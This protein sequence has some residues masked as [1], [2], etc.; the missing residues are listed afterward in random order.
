MILKIIKES[1]IIIKD[2]NP[3]TKN[4]ILIQKQANR[5]MEQNRKCRNRRYVHTGVGPCV[6]MCLHWYAKNTEHHKSIEK[7]WPQASY[8]RRGSHR[9]LEA[10][11]C[12]ALTRYAGK[13]TAMG[14][15]IG[16]M[17]S[18]WISLRHTHPESVWINTV[19]Q[20]DSV[21]HTSDFKFSSSRIKKEILYIQSSI[22]SAC[23]Q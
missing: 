15:I 2:L 19:Q 22:I 1:D 4:V 21:N 11:Q 5:S 20:K 3:V 9:H 18:K 12:R 13:G 23:N 8:T 17:A 14:P 6:R 7:S 16:S 10:P